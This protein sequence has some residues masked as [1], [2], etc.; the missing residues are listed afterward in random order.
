[1]SVLHFATSSLKAE[2]KVTV[3]DTDVAEKVYQ[4]D[5]LLTEF[6]SK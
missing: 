1:M 4:L 5:S 6:F 2:K 3:E